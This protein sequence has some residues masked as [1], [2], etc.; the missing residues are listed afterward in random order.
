MCETKTEENAD[1]ESNGRRKESREGK[2]ERQKEEN[3]R[4][5]GHHRKKEYE[6]GGEGEQ[7]RVCEVPRDSPAFL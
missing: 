1:G 5:S 3:F 7:L 6:G 2:D 4:E